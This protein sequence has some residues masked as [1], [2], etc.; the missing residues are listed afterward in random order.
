MG[1]NRGM[2]K[3]LVKGPALSQS[4]YGEHTRFVLRSLRSRQDLFDI[5]LLNINWGNMGWIWEDN[6]E[7]RWI[8]SLLGKT[9]QH[10]QQGGTFDVSLQVT[11]PGEFE[12]I[13]PV[14]I[15]IT[16]GVE[17][18]KIS[19][20]WVEKCLM[21]DKII[22]ISE[23]SKHAFVNTEYEARNNATGQNFMAKVT[24]PVEVVGYPVKETEATSMDLKLE[25]DFNFLTVGTWIPRKNLENTIKWF[26]EQFY[27]DNVGLIVKTTTARNSLMDRR[28]CESRLNSLLQEYSQRKCKI[29]LLHGDLTEEEMT[30]LYQHPKVKCLVNI[31]HGEGFGLP[32]FEA[33][34]TGLPIVTM[35][36]GG[37]NDFLH[38]PVKSKS[39]KVQIK[40]MFTRV[41]YDIR[42]VQPEAVWDS[43]IQK[44]SQWAYA[45]EWDYKKALRTVHKN[46]SAAK[47]K[48][49]K[50]KKHLQS[51]FS[52]TQQYEKMVNCIAPDTAQM[53]ASIDE[54]FLQLEQR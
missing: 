9:I 29:Y 6:E 8:D 48:A 32:L 45:K 49:N 22:T 34:Y 10:G 5:Y 42:P 28:H 51:E 54:M 15:G 41:S 39:G 44:D 24:C 12:R 18:T 16:A 26:V 7:R 11:I 52:H 13:A 19:P 37:Q 4:G 47:S 25:T 36:Y 46:I 35:A 14:N 50:L 31:S 33:A 17:T 2:K 20:T 3:I 21:M 30:G 43:V 40:P 1:V 53:D 23:Y 38:M 27:E